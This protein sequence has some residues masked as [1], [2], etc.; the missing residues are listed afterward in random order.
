M[1]LKKLQDDTS[2]CTLNYRSQPCQG[3]RGEIYI[4]FRKYRPV[5][6]APQ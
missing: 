3:L 1:K 6:V 5:A 4:S 2:Q